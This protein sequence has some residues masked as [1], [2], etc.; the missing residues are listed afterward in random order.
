[1][2]LRLVEAETNNP[3][4]IGPQNMGGIGPNITVLFFYPYS[5]EAIQCSPFISVKVQTLENDGEVFHLAPPQPSKQFLIS[6]L[7]SPPADWQSKTDDTPVINYDLLYAV[8]KLGP[9]Q[10]HDSSYFQV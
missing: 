5:P 8:S 3:L 4:E 10:F 7:A 6:P 2:P 9:G 1:M